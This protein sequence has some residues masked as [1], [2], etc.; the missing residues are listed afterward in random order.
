[1]WLVT[2]E[3]EDMPIITYTFLFKSETNALRKA[4]EL[5]DIYPHK[6]IRVRAIQVQDEPSL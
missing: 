3:M 1:M 6:N 2:V 4:L 5:K